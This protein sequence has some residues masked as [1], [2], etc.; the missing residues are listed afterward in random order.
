MSPLATLRI[1]VCGILLAAG[2]EKVGGAEKA[3]AGSLP[4]PALSFKTPVN[5]SDIKLFSTVVLL[6]TPAKE[7]PYPIVLFLGRDTQPRT[8]LLSFKLSTTGAVL[9]NLPAMAENEGN[10]V[11]WYNVS[12]TAET[13][14]S[15]NSVNII[16]AS[17]PPPTVRVVPDFIPVG[18]DYMVY[19]NAPSQFFNITLSIYYRHLRPPVP[20]EV[21]LLG[22]LAVEGA[23]VGV[24]AK[25]TD[26]PAGARVEYFCRMEVFHNQRLYK[27]PLSTSATATAEE[28]PVRLVSALPGPECAG[29]LQMQVRGSWAPVCDDLSQPLSARAAVARVVCRQLGCGDVVLTS[30]KSVPS[31]GVQ[32]LMGP[33]KCNGTEAQLRECSLNAF[34]SSCYRGMQVEVVC[35]AFLPPPVLSVSGHGRV[36][37]VYVYEKHPLEISCTL[38]AQWLRG[39][40]IK[41]VEVTDGRIHSGSSVAHGASLTWELQPPVRPGK[42]ACYVTLYGFNLN[43]QSGLSNSVIVTTGSWKPPSAGLIVGALLAALAGAGILV[44]MCVFRVTKKGSQENTAP[45]EARVEIPVTTP[46]TGAE[47]TPGGNTENPQISTEDPETAPGN[48]TENPLTTPATNTENPGF[49]PGEKH[50]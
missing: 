4:V 20:E 10:F 27:S 33:A 35:S 49:S 22:S 17:I 29:E 26:M 45:Q 15:S 31:K 42:Y 30:Y 2:W 16:I 5:G 6:C 23:I 40:Q 1:T 11:C 38:I 44:Y 47:N 3:S 9:F 46:W 39:T 34:L 37:S 24:E 32:F 21:Q 43:T 7:T 14:G 8:E 36:S 48:S 28:A 18:G 50:T 19:C 41:L 12:R 25:R 13:S